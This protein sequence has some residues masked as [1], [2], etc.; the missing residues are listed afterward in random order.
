[1]DCS[2]IMQ[3]PTEYGEFPR[4]LEEY[5]SNFKKSCCDNPIPDTKKFDHT[6]ISALRMLVLS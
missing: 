3:T 2:D 5:F 6:A 4:R 1:M